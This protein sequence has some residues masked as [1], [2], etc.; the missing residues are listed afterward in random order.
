MANYVKIL[1]RDMKSKGFSYK[2][3]INTDIIPW[4]ENSKMGLHFCD[5][6]YFPLFLHHGELIAD[7]KVLKN[8]PKIK[9]EYGYKSHRI[10]IINIR[11]ISTLDIWKDIEFC[12]HAVSLNGDSIKYVKKQ[13]E[14]MANIAIKNNPYSL[15][16]INQ[17]IINT[18]MCIEAVKQEGLTLAFVPDKLKNN[19]I[20][21]IAVGNNQYAEQYINSNKAVCELLNEI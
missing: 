3:G 12:M 7:V 17:K 20:V 16:Y 18:S 21:Q 11:P 10:E 4:D 13:T 5:F 8:N 19:I 2:E 15:F 14:D 1:P 9:T 6:K